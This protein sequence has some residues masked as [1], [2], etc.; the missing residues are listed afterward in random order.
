VEKYHIP[1]LF[2]APGGQIDPGHIADLMSQVDYAP[3]LLGLLNWTYASRFFGWD[4]RKASGDRRALIGN[5]QKLGLYE[6]G[7]LS[8]VG[9]QRKSAEFNYDDR[10]HEVTPKTPSLTGEVIAYYQTA[11]YLYRNS[12]YRELSVADQRRQAGLP[13]LETH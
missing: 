5:Y 7:V 8:M 13:P 4:I 9:P 6:E 11:S 2:Y 10:T 3:T 12:L 1:M